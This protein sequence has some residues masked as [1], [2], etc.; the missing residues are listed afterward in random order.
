MSYE[1]LYC[2]WI[3][4]TLP[5]F[6]LSDARYTKPRVEQ[7]PPARSWYIVFFPLSFPR[8]VSKRFLRFLS[9]KIARSPVP[10]LPY[11]QT[12]ELHR[13]ANFWGGKFS[14]P[15]GEG[16]EGMKEGGGGWGDKK[17]LR[18]AAASLKTALP[19]SRPSYDG[20]VDRYMVHLSRWSVIL[21]E[22]KISTFFENELT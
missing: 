1:N 6:R 20:K 14:F 18:R 15:M 4:R 10:F 13:A 19:K 2:K 17:I 7:P 3:F 5:R 21:G 22:C 8:N 11:V 16:E 9:F 12:V